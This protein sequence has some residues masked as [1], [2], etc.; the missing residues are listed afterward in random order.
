RRG[1]GGRMG[2]LRWMIATGEALEMEVAR[3]WRRVQGEV[4]LMNAY[5]PTECSDDV[6]HE[7]VEGK[8]E[9][10]V[11]AIGRPVINTEIYVA[12]EVG[13]MATIG[14]NGKIYVGGE[15][16]GRGYMKEAGKTAE[17]FVPNVYGG[18]AGEVMYDT[19]DSGR[20]RS[21]GRIEYTGRRD[22]Q[23]KVRG[24]RIELG[25]IETVLNEMSGLK[26]GVVIATEGS[27]G[28]TRLAAFVVS[29]DGLEISGRDVRSYL[30]ERLPVFM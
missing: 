13:G 10:E 22:G 21:D 16:V 20:Y 4:K 23:V 15:G 7:K 24:H 29:R 5:G 28:D 6:T 12:D 27:G 30:R 2:G 25:E 1:G 14:V 3:D 17:V 11:V 9:E 8:E 26:Q 18:K 19:G